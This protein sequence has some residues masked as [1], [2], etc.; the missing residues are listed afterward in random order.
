MSNDTEQRVAFITGASR[1]I[2]YESAKQMAAQGRL[3]VCAGR[4]QET[5]KKVVEEIEGMGYAADFAVCDVND[6]NAITECIDAV[7]DRHG[8]LDILVNNAG[9]TR[10]NL[11]LR[12]T[13]EEFDDVIRVN[14]RSVFIASRAALR[15]MMRKKWGR[16]I[17]IS[18]VAGVIGNS[19]QT[20]YAAAKSGL[21]GFTKSLAREM[22]AKHITAN[23]VAPGF[24]ETAMTNDLPQG[25]KDFARNAT[26][27]R[28]FGLPHEIAAAIAFL[29]SEDAGFITGQT[30]SVDGGM[31]MC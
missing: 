17:N 2:G 8:R 30:L 28:R 7:A 31:S 21:C 23:V 25:V 13:D 12:M 4:H 15:P 27:L 1:G 20:N 22:A 19:G 9:M 14:L 29:A 16:I 10:D 6:G 3:V 11:L 26:P 24:V 18:S 5:L